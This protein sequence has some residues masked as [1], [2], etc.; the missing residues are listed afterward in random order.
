[1]SG[2]ISNWTRHVKICQK[3]KKQPDSYQQSLLGFLSPSS[4][5]SESAGSSS[6]Y[7][8]EGATPDG[9]VSSHA[10][11]NDNILGDDLP[12]LPLTPLHSDTDQGFAGAPL[13]VISHQ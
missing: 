12:E 10:G 9:S 13:S 3:V 6:S 7:P 1:M 4:S 5:T 2:S 8:S 11:D